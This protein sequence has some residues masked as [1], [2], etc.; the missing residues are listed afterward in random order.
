MHD[1]C[2]WSST[3]LKCPVFCDIMPCSL[4]KIN[5]RFDTTYFTHGLFFDPDDGGCSSRNVSGIWTHYAALYPRK[6]NLKSYTELICKLRL[7]S[8][9]GQ[10]T[11]WVLVWIVP[12]TCWHVGR[13]CCNGA[14][15]VGTDTGLMCLPSRGYSA[16]SSVT[17]ENISIV[18]ASVTLSVLQ[19]W[20]R[21]SGNTPVF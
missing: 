3:Y 21:K 2:R 12:L 19:L 15:S 13:H 17:W 8:F 9:T 10:T 5:R 14:M 11:V 4:S 16:R 18:N 6:Q 7:Q 20:W 1:P